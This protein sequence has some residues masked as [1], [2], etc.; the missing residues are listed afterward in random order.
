[1]V[2]LRRNV[3]ENVA[4][5]S[6]AIARS[7]FTFERAYS[8]WGSSGDSSVT[9]AASDMPYMMHEEENRNRCTPAALANSARRTEA[10]KLIPSVQCGLRLPIG[11]LLSAARWT[12]ASNPSRSAGSRFLRSLRMEGTLRAGGIKVQSAK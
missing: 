5:A 4:S 2:P 1:M 12:T 3:G 8:V 10:W 6:C 9:I 11:S 7:A